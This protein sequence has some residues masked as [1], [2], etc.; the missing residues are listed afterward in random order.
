ME[1]PITSAGPKAVAVASAARA[2]A[3]SK[4]LKRSSQSGLPPVSPQPTAQVIQNETLVTDVI[5][6]YALAK[7]EKVIGKEALA[8][9][10][11]ALACLWE[12]KTVAEVPA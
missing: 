4:R 11:A 10:V 7:G 12:G 6:D 2:R 5:A 1:Q 3:I 9:N 8:N